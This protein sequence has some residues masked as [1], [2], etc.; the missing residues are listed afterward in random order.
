MFR[1]SFLSLLCFA[2]IAHAQDA[3]PGLTGVVTIP[4]AEPPSVTSLFAS[5]NHQVFAGRASA[6]DQSASGIPLFSFFVLDAGGQILSQS[7]GLKIPADFVA[8]SNQGDLWTAGIF[9][10]GDQPLARID[11]S[12]QVAWRAPLDFNPRA[13]AVDP[14]GRGVVA[15]VAGGMAAVAAIDPVTGAPQF[16]VKFGGVSTQCANGGACTPATAP[17]AIVTGDDGSIYIAGT[18]NATD[19]PVT[20][21]AAHGACGDCSTTTSRVFAVRLSPAGQILYATYLPYSPGVISLAVD[22][23]G[24]MYVAV[25]AQIISGN[26]YLVALSPSGV[27]IYRTTIPFTVTQISAD[28]ASQVTGVKPTFFPNPPI[29]F[30]LSPAGELNAY[31]TVFTSSDHTTVPVGDSVVGIEAG[32]PAFLYRW[33][34]AESPSPAI[35]HMASSEGQHAVAQVAPGE[36][37]SFYGSGLGPATAETAVFDANGL[38]PVQL[39]ASVC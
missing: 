20:P 38:L 1:P 34:M 28:D 24:A 27:E 30:R 39:A 19:F 37:L 13:I 8:V 32:Q 33:T 4:G 18:T 3:R 11:K 35:T 22:R 12:G 14:A 2:A 9:C 17:A 29:A 6:C 21:S 36:L 5:P 16:T 15:G 10:A 25:S 7:A 31:G 26:A 23:Q